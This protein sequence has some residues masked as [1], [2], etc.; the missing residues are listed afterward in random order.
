MAAA[1][2][3]RGGAT[4]IIHALQSSQLLP[5]AMQRRGR[6]CNAEGWVDDGSFIPLFFNSLRRCSSSPAPFPSPAQPWASYRVW[7][8]QTR[9][10]P[11]ELRLV[12]SHFGASAHLAPPPGVP[13][14]RH[15]NPI[16]TH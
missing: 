16:S 10:H 7:R 15:K 5:C 6:D 4:D 3:P 14:T 12:P 9:P 13:L 1:P 2:P 11:P 8:M